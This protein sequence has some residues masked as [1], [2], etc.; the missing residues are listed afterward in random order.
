M[1]SRVCWDHNDGKAGGVLQFV[2]S[3]MALLVDPVLLSLLTSVTL[4]KLMYELEHAQLVFIRI[5]LRIQWIQ[6]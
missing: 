2:Q 3:P 5:G 1:K 6:V 4:S